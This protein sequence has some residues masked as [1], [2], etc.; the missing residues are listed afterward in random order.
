MSKTKIVIIFCVIGFS[1][2]MIKPISNRLSFINAN[3]PNDK[4]EIQFKGN[5]AEINRTF[6]FEYKGCYEVGLYS[7]TNTFAG[8]LMESPNLQGNYTLTYSSNS[9]IIQAKNATINKDT[10]TTGYTRVGRR[11]KHSTL[12]L[13]VIEAKHKKLNINLELKN[14]DQRILNDN[15]YFYAREAGFP[16]GKKKELLDSKKIATPETNETL[17]P[18]YYSL[19][20]NNISELKNFFQ[21]TKLPHNVTML[22]NR[23]AL[24]YAVY[25]NNPNAASYLLS[26]DRSILDKRDII[27]LTALA[28]GIE[29]IYVDVV[30]ELLR[31]KPDFEI[32]ELQKS[33]PY[34]KAYYY[35][36]KGIMEFLFE[37]KTHDWW[38]LA[39]EYKG[40]VDQTQHDVEGMMEALLDAGLN[41]NV[42]RAPEKAAENSSGK[43]FLDYAFS[44]QRFREYNIRDMKQYEEENKTNDK[45][46][47]N[48]RLQQDYMRIIQMLRDHGGKTF[49]ELN[50]QTNTTTQG[51]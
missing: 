8:F 19:Q 49:A 22:G 29:Y 48:Y 2:A 26:K 13:D 51:E 30:K 14:L 4:T 31:Y 15:I 40:F 43:T 37:K 17:K 18:L 25:F 16:C 36:S 32:V 50:N 12:M 39:N 46:Y 1:L 5:T 35:G 24:H 23:T 44:E 11:T 27:G 28:Y 47:K 45:Y 41:P 6:E 21:T 7:K 38:N 10:K 42:I 20:N 3:I 34:E 33:F 9:T